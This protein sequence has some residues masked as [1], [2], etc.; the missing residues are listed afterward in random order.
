MLGRLASGV[1]HEVNNPLAGMLNAIDT[2]QTYCHDPAVLQASLDFLK[3]GLAGIRNVVRATLVTYKGGSETGILTGIDLDDLRYLVQHE[4][5][6]RHLHL[7]WDNRIGEPLSIDGPAVRQITLNLLLNA[8]AASPEGG[9][10]AVAVSHCAG[11]S[12]GKFP[13]PRQSIWPD[14]QGLRRRQ[15]AAH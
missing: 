13:T 11:F 3:R 8:C 9:L 7:E 6:A 14:G 2:I 10:V 1:A 15:G 12:V 4:S 5:G